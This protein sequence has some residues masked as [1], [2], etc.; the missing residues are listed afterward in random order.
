M[1]SE[2][3]RLIGEEYLLNAKKSSIDISLP[4]GTFSYSSLAPRASLSFRHYFE[5]EIHKQNRAIKL[6]QYSNVTVPI[7]AVIRSR[8]SIRTF[9]GEKLSMKELSTVLYYGDGVSGFLTIILWG[10]LK[11]QSR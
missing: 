3:S 6:P 2:E 1:I 5:E 7:G 9:S 11:Q 8:R 4:I 10:V